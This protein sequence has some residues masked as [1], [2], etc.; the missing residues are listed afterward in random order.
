[1]HFVYFGWQRI[2]S[3]NNYNK[4]IIPASYQTQK[5]MQSDFRISTI[6]NRKLEYK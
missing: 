3:N 2:E 6:L 5:K 1:M 4:N